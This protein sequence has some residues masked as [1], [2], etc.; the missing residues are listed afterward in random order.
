MSKSK[1][2]MRTNRL[3]L[4]FAAASI[5]IIRKLIG[6]SALICLSAA[7][8]TGG[9][10]LLN[11]AKLDGT[12]FKDSQGQMAEAEATIT[13]AVADS[14]ESGLDSVTFR[15]DREVSGKQFIAM[16]VSALQ[17]P[18]VAPL[19]DNDDDGQR[20]ELYLQSLFDAGILQEG[21]FT[22]EQLNHRLLHEDMIRLAVSA[23]EPE[24]GAAAEPDEI[25]RKAE[26]AGLLESGQG[27]EQALNRF[28][29][30]EEAAFVLQKLQIVLGLK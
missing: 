14:T 3:K 17:L 28:A 9:S 7:L 6:I 4:F 19:S 18:L 24:G 29:T 27:E 21:D 5:A 16:L 30:R 1:I 10:P 25:K 26:A 8:L 22:V 15:T 11:A 20:T 12:H 2:R 23:L 13:D